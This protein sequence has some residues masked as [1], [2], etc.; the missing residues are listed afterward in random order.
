MTKKEMIWNMLAD[1][2]NLN[3]EKYFRTAYRKSAEIIS[4]IYEQYSMAQEKRQKSALLSLLI[5]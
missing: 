2:A 4:R 5:S 3:D 1:S